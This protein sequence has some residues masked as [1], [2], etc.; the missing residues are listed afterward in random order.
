MNWK[1]LSL[2]T[3]VESMRKVW[4]RFPF[5]CAFLVAF[6]AWLMFLVWENSLP[7]S[8]SA[9][10]KGILV[11]YLGTGVLLSTVLQLWCEEIRQKRTAFLL[12][13]GTHLLWLLNAVLLFTCYD[14]FTHSITAGMWVAVGGL[15]VCLP[16][17]PFF[18]EK[19]DM[20]SWNFGVRLI[21]WAGVSVG[22]SLLLFGGFALLIESLETL[23]KI[24][25]SSHTYETLAVLF[26]VALPLSIW[27]SKVPEGEEKYFREPFSSGFALKCVRFLLVPLLICY[28][29]VLYVYGL[30]SLLTWM[31]PDGYVSTL[32]TVLMG[33]YLFMSL[34]YYA[35]RKDRLNRFDHWLLRNMPLLFF[36]LVLMMSIG[37]V[38]RFSD[39]GVTANRL[40]VLLLN[41]WFYY[42]LARMY[43]FP[44]KRINWVGVSL[45]GIMAVVSLFPVNFHSFSTSIR[46]NEVR[47]ALTEQLGMTLPVTFED[48]E[49][50]LQKL[51]SDDS[52]K[53]NEKCIYLI[54]RTD[55]GQDL[56]QIISYHSRNSFYHDKDMLDYENG[57]LWYADNKNISVPEGFS[58]FVEIDYLFRA[59]GEKTFT[60][61][62]ESGRV[63][64]IESAQF[65]KLIRQ[66]EQYQKDNQENM[67]AVT[68]PC[69]DGSMLVC[70][71]VSYT[72]G[73]ESAHL[74]GYL[75]YR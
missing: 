63:L 51:P 34:L 15:F 73:R 40:Y 70:T 1:K 41:L 11:Y 5:A 59:V 10:R 50:A 58:H 21:F 74:S 32:V 44:K 27:L 29:A 61:N 26:L 57:Y 67:E 64:E 45:A 28:M 53:F 43:F 22:V 71:G 48:Y 54:W 46:L 20:A 68:I 36:P 3:L 52:K 49:K 39:Y 7:K 4:K 12:E 42:V 66:I 55:G 60:A 37:L 30:K 2:R 35:V 33:G 24:R 18:R 62:L 14:D 65:D 38:R 8:F 72:S 9:Y 75:F 69:T 56:Q 25:I 13:R 31:L 16:T 47:T 17:V 19:D 6:V 23:F